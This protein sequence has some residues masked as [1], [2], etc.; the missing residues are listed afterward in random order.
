MDTR[1]VERI[2]SFIKVQDSKVLEVGPGY[3]VLTRALL[4]QGATVVAVELDPALCESLQSMFS[5]EI[6]CERLILIRGDATRCPLPPFDKV[7]SNLPYSVSSRITFRLLNIGF[8]EAVLMF[9][10]EFAERMIARPGTPGCGRLSIM[11]QTYADIEPCFELS[12]RAFNPMPRV[13]SMV[14]H[15]VPHEP[16]FPLKDR[17]LYGDVVRALFSNRRKTVRNG[18][19]SLRSILEPGQLDLLLS[20]VPDDILASRP[21]ELQLE[22]FALIA[23]S[24]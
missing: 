10:K 16:R 20:F 13:R 19:K 12:P 18:L 6:E 5:A 14:L 3:G 7:V 1:A 24:G 17:K 23:N 22:D 2:L 9:Q 15:L 8:S 11:V 4:E 21:E